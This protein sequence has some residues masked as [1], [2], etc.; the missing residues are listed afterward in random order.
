[1]EAYFARPEDVILYKLI[2]SQQSGSELHLRDVLGILS[3]S[4]P[5][6]DEAYIEEWAGRIGLRAIWEQIRKQATHKEQ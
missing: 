2:Y 6:L 4:G 1:M 3:V 5:E